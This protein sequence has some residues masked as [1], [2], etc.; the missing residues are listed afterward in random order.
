MAFSEFPED[1]PV[2]ELGIAVGSRKRCPCRV[3]VQSATLALEADTELLDEP[4]TLRFSGT[5]SEA[6]AVTLAPASGPVQKIS[7][8]DTPGGDAGA[9]AL[10]NFALPGNGRTG[11]LLGPDQRIVR[12]LDLAA[13]L[14]LA[15]ISL[16]WHPLSDQATWTAQLCA[17][18][19]S[20]LA[21]AALIEANIRADT[22]AAAWIA[23]RWPP[24]DLQSCRYWLGLA[25]KEGSGLW[26]HAEAG[27]PV[28]GW[29]EAARSPQLSPSPLGG[30]PALGALTP[31]DAPAGFAVRVGGQTL[32]LLA[33]DQGQGLEAE[34]S[35]APPAAV[36]ATFDIEVSQTLTL[37]VESVR[38]TQRR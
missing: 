12:A 23:L 13:P 14:R 28:P 21:G 22:P 10:G 2:Q 18:A 11:T 38:V 5:R 33:A 20:Q 3:T 35:F 37:K 26:L 15:G 30:T 9:A 7:I 34:H 29:V 19:G 4:Q 36:G 32:A 31:G 25:A 17:D 8:S 24:V 1:S 27:P 16:P 6:L